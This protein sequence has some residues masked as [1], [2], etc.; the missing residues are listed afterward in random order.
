MKSTLPLCCLFVN[1]EDTDTCGK[2]CPIEQVLPSP[3]TASSRS[4]SSSFVPDLPFR[5]FPEQ[6]T[7][8]EHN[9]HPPVRILPSTRS[10]AGPRH[11]PRNSQE[12]SRQSYGHRDHSPRD[13]HPSFLGNADWRHQSDLLIASPSKNPGRRSVS[14]RMILKSSS[15][16]RNH[17]HTGNGRG[18]QVLFLTI[19][20]GSRR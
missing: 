16:C 17:V 19:E 1:P 5:P 4:D 8:R 3:I 7:L 18:R 6:R 10:C 11:N 15:P 14:P 20:F 13:P 2:R 9:R 12:A